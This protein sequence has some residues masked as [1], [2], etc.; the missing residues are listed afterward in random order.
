MILS[1]GVY[2]G[3]AEFFCFMD[4]FRGEVLSL[5]VAGHAV[6]HL[7]TAPRVC[8]VGSEVMMS[9]CSDVS[10]L[11]CRQ[12]KAQNV[13]HGRNSGVIHATA[14]AASALR[15][16]FHELRAQLRL[17]P[18]ILEKIFMNRGISPGS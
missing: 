13:F 4:L 5:A 1:V 10:S 16:I 12:G 9:A 6:L 3:R 11:S 7:V 18:V 15:T 8:G 2:G 14:V 17:R